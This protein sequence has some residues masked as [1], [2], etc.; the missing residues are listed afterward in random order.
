MTAGRFF[1]A[2]KNDRGARAGR[3]FDWAVFGGVTSG[4]AQIVHVVHVCARSSN[5][6]K[7]APGQ[8]A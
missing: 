8:E 6:L 1:A 5:M 2:L 3:P 4:G 7:G